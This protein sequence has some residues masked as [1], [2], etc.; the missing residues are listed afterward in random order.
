[1]LHA[2]M[3]GMTSFKVSFS[4]RKLIKLFNGV[5]KKCNF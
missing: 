5:L 2:L 1:M 4:Q 3:N